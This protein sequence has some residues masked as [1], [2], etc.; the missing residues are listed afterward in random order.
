MK[1]KTKSLGSTGA[2]KEGLGLDDAQ[3]NYNYAAN[4]YWDACKQIEELKAKNKRYETALERIANHGGGPP[5]TL[6]SVMGHT[7]KVALREK[8][9]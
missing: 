4:M 3:P 7:A 9:N 6:V 8:S 2:A 5:Q 1:Q